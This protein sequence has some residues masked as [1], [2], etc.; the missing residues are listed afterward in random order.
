M[1]MAKILK[2]ETKMLDNFEKELEDASTLIA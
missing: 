1:R 2:I